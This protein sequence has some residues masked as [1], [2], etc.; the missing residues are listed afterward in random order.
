MLKFK[1]IGIE[2]FHLID[3]YFSIHKL[4]ENGPR[5]C[6]YAPGTVK[7]WHKEY[8]MEYAIEGDVMYLR[9][10]YEEE[11]GTSYLMPVGRLDSDSL[12]PLCEYIETV[13]EATLSVMPEDMRG[14]VARLFGVS[15]DRIF[16][17]RD[18]ADYIYLKEEFCFPS[19]K[20]H[21]NY[22]YN[23]NKFEKE[24]PDYR[25]EPLGRNN[26]G[27][28]IE[29][30]SAYCKDNPETSSVDDAEYRA[31]V[32]VILDPELYSMCGAVLIVDG[33]IVGLTLGEVYKDTVIVHTEKALKEMAGAYQTLARGFQLMMPESV[34]Y[35]NREEDMGLLGLRRSKL[36]YSPLRLDMKYTLYLK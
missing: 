7:M 24:H 14:E 6:D 25:I 15:E 2:D 22:K 26:V 23:L 1:S 12:K 30:Y 32:P 34:K 35:I 36:S 3:K 10:S 17:D 31:T 21:H 19:G 16:A 13:T 5:F 8:K 18:W 33:R 29:F 4:C 11:A 20:K 28:A 27:E 9:A